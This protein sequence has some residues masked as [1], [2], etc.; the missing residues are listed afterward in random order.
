M[1]KIDRPPSV[2]YGDD[3]AHWCRQQASLL[4]SGFVTRL[5]RENLAEEIEGL[6]GSQEDE[7][8]SRI[9]V[10]LQHLLN[11]QYQ[12]GH[13]SGSWKS[14]ILE[15]RLRIARRIRKSPS[16]K[17][18]PD[19]VYREGYASA[20]LKAA[21]ETGLPE[22]AFPQDCPFTVGEILDQGWFPE[23]QRNENLAGRR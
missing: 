10:L 22:D 13:R 16:L 23:S 2:A 4:R 18:Y 14:T 19:E 1:N 7:I 8:E 21:G 20:R 9:D 15:Q 3:F 12:P 5:D 11:W 17:T 6:S